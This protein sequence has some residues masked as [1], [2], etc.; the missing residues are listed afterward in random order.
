MRIRNSYVFG[1]LACVLLAGCHTN[2]PGSGTTGG[3]AA[4]T[5]SSPASGGPKPAAKDIRLGFLVKQPEEPWFQNEWTFATMCAEKYGFQLDKIGAVDGNTVL[6]AIDTLASHGAQGF[7]ICTPDVKLGPSI[8]NRAQAH[9]MKV[10]S[11][12]DQFIGSDGKFMDV[13]YMGISARDIGHQVG[14]TLWDE[15][16]KRGW[17]PEDTAVCAITH[18]EL[19]T[20]KERT[21]GA[22]EILVKNGFPEA[23]IYKGAEKTTDVEGGMNAATIILTQHPEVKHWLIYSMNDEGALGAVRA[24]ENA[25]FNADTAIACGIGGT[26]AK[27]EFKKD[28]PTSFFATVLISPRRHGYETTELLYKWVADGTPPPKDTR[29]TGIVVYRDTCEKVMKEQGLLK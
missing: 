13:P 16:K 1:A 28:K 15:Y 21:D 4:T 11:V 20:A 18:E 25:R 3:G 14:Q 23:K 7:V 19:N 24:M 26:T 8:V 10:F 22:Q 17:N 2:Q 9:N 29:T 27:D 12:D 6:S 5:G